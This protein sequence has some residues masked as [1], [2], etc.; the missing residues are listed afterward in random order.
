MSSVEPGLFKS[1]T[2]ITYQAQSDLKVKSMGNNITK[3]IKKTRNQ[4]PSFV[5][6]E[7]HISIM[8]NLKSRAM[9]KYILL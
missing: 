4:K 7:E 8:Q 2:S 9:E 5:N 3:K 6:P 1:Y